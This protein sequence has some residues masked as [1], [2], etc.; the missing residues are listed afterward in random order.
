MIKLYT[1]EDGIELWKIKKSFWAWKKSDKENYE[2]SNIPFLVDE[3]D[4]RMEDY[5]IK[6]G[7]EIDILL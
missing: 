1:N 5:L 3:K 2:E 7:A 4:V 6:A